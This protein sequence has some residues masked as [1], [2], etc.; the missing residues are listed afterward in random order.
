MGFP[1]LCTK[2]GGMSYIREYTHNIAFIM[3]IIFMH[4]PPS[5]LS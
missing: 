1:R 5:R 2:N 3:D 4:F